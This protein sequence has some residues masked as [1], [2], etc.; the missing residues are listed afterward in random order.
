MEEEN[1]QVNIEQPV[2]QPTVEAPQEP[3]KKKN[4]LPAI[5]VL[6]V[7]LAAVIGVAVFLVLNKSDK[8]ENTPKEETEKLNYSVYIYKEESEYALEECVTKSDTCK[9]VV[10]EIKVANSD[11]SIED[12]QSNGKK[13]SYLL[14]KDGEKY[15]IYNRKTKET[16]TLNFQ[17]N[18]KNVELGTIGYGDTLEVVGLI[19]YDRI[20]DKDGGEYNTNAGYYNIAKDQKM[21]EGKFDSIEVETKDFLSA[22]KYKGNGDRR[23]D[24]ENIYAYLLSANEEKEI[25]SE[26][27]AQCISFGAIDTK[28]SYFI[29]RYDGCTGAS[30]VS[31]YSNDK[32]ILVKDIYSSDYDF[33]DNYVDIYDKNKV[34]TY[35]TTGKKIK[36]RDVNG[37]FM[38]IS[39]NYIFYIENNKIKVTD[40]DKFV[41]ELA[42]WKEE[43]YFHWMISGYYEGEDLE[44]EEEKEDG[45]YLVIGLDDDETTAGFEIFFNP[46]NQ[47]SKRFELEE[48][49]GYAKPILYLYPEKETKVTVDFEHEDKLTTTYPKF[50]NN[51]TV[52]AKP[53]GDLYD[54]N[55][56]YYYGLYW[57][58]DLNH[59]VDFHEGFYVTKENAIEFLEE[60]LTYIGL[61]EKERNEFIMYW[62][63]ILEKN[64]KNLVYFELTEER[65]SYNKLEITPKPDSLLRVAIHVKKV[66]KETKI[67]EQKLQTFNRKG[68]TAVEW[69][70]VQYK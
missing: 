15:K 46:K 10:E 41:K 9:E 54:A 68:F 47:T 64:G 38:M 57:E 5:I 29:M 66:N 42:E 23:D 2:E 63:P 17:T 32:K 22:S 65:D 37:K 45:I 20:E 51:W 49:G 31:I 19:Y 69:G 50:K 28:D 6:I 62:L 70:G 60:K 25:M 27:E 61:N 12:W 13:I 35:D 1:K 36:E 67:K 40:G 11:A 18:R 16:T 24:E 48:I 34:I 58:E 52:T 7:L 53:N 44:Y 39:E 21:Y 33:G 4:M 30:S 55:G 14:I 26:N 59:P 3:A 56:K 43:Y 8:K